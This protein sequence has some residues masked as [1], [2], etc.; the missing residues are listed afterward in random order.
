MSR[1]DTLRRG[2]G[3]SVALVLA[4]KLGIV[5]LVLVLPSGLAFS[6]GAAHGLVLLML[7]VAAAV[8]L[9]ARGIERRR[10]SDR[11]H[12]GEQRMLTAVAHVP[13]ANASRYLVQLCQHATKISHRLGHLHAT[14]ARPEV[15]D[16]DWSDTHGTL[17]LSWGQ[18][19]LDADPTTLT[20]RVDAVDEEKLRQ[21]QD[22]IAADLGRFGRRDQL[23]VTWQPG[24]AG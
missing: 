6:L 12:L 9:I 21:I 23:S 13:T 1:H 24:E 8:L 14:R 18:C 17:S 7:G 2:K 20:V 4:V 16:V 11:P 19:T 15:L 22:V 3:R 10:A 5:V